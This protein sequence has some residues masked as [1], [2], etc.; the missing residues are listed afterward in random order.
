[1]T[2]F[3]TLVRFGIV[4]IIATLVYAAV[5]FGLIYLDVLNAAAIN[6]L[7]LAAA[8]VSS[9]AGHHRFTYGFDGNNRVYGARFITATLFLVG[10]STAVTHVAVSN[11]GVSPQANALFISVAY[12]AFSTVLHHF[13]TFS[14]GRP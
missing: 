8:L 9:Y 7:A 1:M 3:L 5:S 6:V 14:R 11:L 10:L 13:W 12:P 2:E 4:G